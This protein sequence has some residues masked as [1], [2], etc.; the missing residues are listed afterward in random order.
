MA[1]L[2]QLLRSIDQLTAQVVALSGRLAGS[3]TCERVEGL[4]IE[5]VMGLI[6]GWTHADRRA[7]LQ[8][9]QVLATMPQVASLFFDQA[10]LS[11]GQV[12]SIVRDVRD[13]TVDERR[14]VD[15]AVAARF[16]EAPDADPDVLLGAVDAAIVALTP[17]KVERDELRAVEASFLSIQ[18]DLWGGSR[19]YWELDPDSPAA[20]GAGPNP[21]WW[22]QQVLTCC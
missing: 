13:L 9:A 7:L 15:A 1:R 18:P 4:P 17:E 5:Q 2:V 22:S 21:S 6:G 11:W 14:L 8:T 3:G 20:G 16:V 10:A 19:G 12:R